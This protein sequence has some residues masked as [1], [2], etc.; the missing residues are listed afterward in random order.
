VRPVGERVRIFSSPRAPLVDLTFGGRYAP[1]FTSS[2]TEALAL[3]LALASGAKQ[4]AN[5]A[6]LLPGYACPNLVS[7]AIAAGL[8]PR[9]CDIQAG[10]PYLSPSCVT[11]AATQNCVAIV[12]AHFL[13]L[14]HPLADL[15][16]I[17]RKTDAVLIEDAAQMLVSQLQPQASLVVLSF[18]R[19]KPL[20]ILHGG[21]LLVRIAEWGATPAL[22]HAVRASSALGAARRLARRL[23]YNAAIQP[24]AYELVATMPGLG[25]GVVRY[26]PLV[27]GE[28]PSR[29]EL[30]LLTD[31]SAGAV[32]SRESSRALRRLLADFPG[33]L[34]DLALPQMDPEPSLLR[35]PVLAP[36]RDV[37]DRLVAA[38]NRERLGASSLY[39]HALPDIADVPELKSTPL[40][41]ARDF[42]ARLLTLPVHSGV[43]ARHIPR[44]RLVLEQCLGHAAARGSAPP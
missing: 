11:A 3:A 4:R 8:E 18:G 31:G 21:A 44:M 6:V 37:R 20:S 35:Y 36:D 39:A 15:E 25:V 40:V 38:L 1:I 2:G 10:K 27:R 41:N 34:T 42:A 43:S 12:A 26:A 9:L 7:A 13:G 17:G 19:G 32:A 30:G 23:A 5:P 28:R 29:H 22:P 16:E 14:R 33:T 24:A